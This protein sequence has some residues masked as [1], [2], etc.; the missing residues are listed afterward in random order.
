LIYFQGV[1]EANG[2]DLTAST[3]RS[4]FPKIFFYGT[5]K[6]RFFMTDKHS[7]IHGCM[8]LIIDVKRPWEME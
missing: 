3:V 6:T 5:Y 4:G 2:Y 1:Y 7:Y 8:N